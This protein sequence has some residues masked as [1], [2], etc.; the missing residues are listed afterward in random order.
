MKSIF[1]Y[2]IQSTFLNLK[3]ITVFKH[4][5]FQHNSYMARQY[6]FITV[7]MMVDFVR[8]VFTGPVTQ[9]TVSVHWR[10]MIDWSRGL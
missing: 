1:Q 2:G 7:F 3:N 10:R 5:Q 8:W 6:K 4:D 9:P